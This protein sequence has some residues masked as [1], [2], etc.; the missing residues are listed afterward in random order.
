MNSRFSN[1]KRLI[2]VRE[3]GS[4]IPIPSSGND[5]TFEHPPPPMVN[6]LREGIPPMEMICQP[7]SRAYLI[8]EGR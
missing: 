1:W 2:R 5:T 3:G 6:F 7:N 8:V 4:I